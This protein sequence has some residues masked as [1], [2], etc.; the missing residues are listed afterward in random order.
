[1]SDHH[2]PLRLLANDTENLHIISAMLQDT[3]MPVT[4]MVFDEQNQT[5]SFLANRFCWELPEEIHDDT[6]FY[7]RVHAGLAFKTVKRVQKRNFHQ[8]DEK[9][10]LYFLS[11]TFDSSGDH[12][13]IT[14][15]FADDHD[16]RLEVENIDC[17]FADI[18]HPWPTPTQPMH[19]H[20]HLE[21]LTLGQ[22][23]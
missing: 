15:H 9:R 13:H 6:V 2:Q 5:F 1:M 14:L 7:H 17:I 20:E 21:E 22:R 8:A 10:V 18:D 4:A 11:L 3:L 23:G 19:I 16:I 12:P